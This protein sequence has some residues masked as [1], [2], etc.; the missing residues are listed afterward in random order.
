LSA[1]A[2]G[3][4]AGVQH[5][6]LNLW[7]QQGGDRCGARQ[8]QGREWRRQHVQADPAGRLPVCSIRCCPVVGMPEVDSSA[9]A[10]RRRRHPTGPACVSQGGFPGM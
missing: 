10:G 6:N 8:V 3:V 1:H 7:Q 5:L 2:S 9:R 4:S